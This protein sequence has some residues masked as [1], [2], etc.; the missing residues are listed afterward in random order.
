M[1]HSEDVSQN[2]GNI[3]REMYL[4]HP[5]HIKMIKAQVND[6]F[7]IFHLRDIDPSG[8]G[9]AICER[10]CPS[11]FIMSEFAPGTT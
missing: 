1:G 3:Q 5:V 2:H 9:E 8:Q 6:S 4:H 10:C 11:Q 7:R